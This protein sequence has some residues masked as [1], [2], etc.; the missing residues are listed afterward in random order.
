MLTLAGEQS[1]DKEGVKKGG[2]LEDK[3]LPWLMNEIL[4]AGVWNVVFLGFRAV[5]NQMSD[6]IFEILW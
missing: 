5:A 1:F 2:E 3:F 6:K 4:F